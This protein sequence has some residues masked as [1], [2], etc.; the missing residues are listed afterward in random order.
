MPNAQQWR[1]FPPD[2]RSCN[3]E[4]P[5]EKKSIFIAIALPSLAV[6]LYIV[7]LNLRV[8]G[9]AERGVCKYTP[10]VQ[11]LFFIALTCLPSFILG[12]RP[13]PDLR[14]FMA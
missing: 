13:F 2:D 7:V 14:T 1:D 5:E 3:R 10:S 6:I 4:I 9:R 8:S 12:G 11:L